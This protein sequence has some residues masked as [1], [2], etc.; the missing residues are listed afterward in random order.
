MSDN[1]LPFEIPGIETTEEVVE[2]EPVEEIEEEKVEE[3]EKTK[4]T[5]LF[6]F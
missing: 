1:D 6:N 4:Q 2:E 3:K 5:T